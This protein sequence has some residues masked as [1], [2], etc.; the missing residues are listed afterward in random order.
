MPDKQ[1]LRWGV[2]PRYARKSLY[3]GSLTH[4]Q[5]Q[6]VKKIPNTITEIKNIEKETTPCIPCNNRTRTL[7]RN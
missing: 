6:L 5:E 3:R 2:K 4:I 7:G 1:D